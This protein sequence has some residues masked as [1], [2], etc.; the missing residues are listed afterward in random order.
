M[1]QIIVVFL[2]MQN[3]NSFDAKNNT[4]FDQINKTVKIIKIINGVK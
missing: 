1:F 3:V 4:N 2:L